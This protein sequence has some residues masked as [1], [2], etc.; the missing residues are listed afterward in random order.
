MEY[1]SDS[2]YLLTII[3]PVY[4]EEGNVPRLVKELSAYLTLTSYRIKVLFVNDGSNDNSAA[5]LENLC[6]G[7]P[8]F[9]ILHLKRNGGLSTALKAGFDLAESTYVGYIDADLQTSPFDFDRLMEFAPR[10][11]MVTGIRID[12]KD[13]LVKRIS[14]LIAN[15]L[16][17]AVTGDGVSD[18]GCPL[19]VFQTAVLRQIPVFDGMHRF[20]PAL[21][22]LTGECVKEVPVSHFPRLV[23][24][25]NYR[26]TN[27]LFRSAA[28]L[29]A[30]NWIRSRFIRYEINGKK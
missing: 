25:S 4:N 19:K 22:R 23:G 24:K 18:T 20:F 30:F 11:G 21:V 3:V 5:L 16:R 8:D 28:D 29:I 13:G 2:R 10:F 6:A 1:N 15:R 14:S 9:G 12:R 27:R 26:L 17:C 7:N